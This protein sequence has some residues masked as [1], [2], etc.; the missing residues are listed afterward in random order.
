MRR[1]VQQQLIDLL[2]TVK[3]GIEYLFASQGEISATLAGDCLA[4]L[5]QLSIAIEGSGSRKASLYI[6]KLQAISNDLGHGLTANRL[7]IEIQRIESVQ[8]D[9]RQEPVRFEIAFL[10]YKSSMWDCMESVWRAAAA[11]KNCDCHVVPIPYYERIPGQSLGTFRYEGRMLPP[12]VPIVDYKSYDLARRKPDVIYIHNPNDEYNFLTSIDPNYYSYELKRHTDMLVYL[13]YYVAGYADDLSSGTLSALP[14]YQYADR[15]VVQS[16]PMRQGLL[17]LGLPSERI[18]V[19]GSPKFDAVINRNGKGYPAEWQPKLK[20]RTAFLV[21]TSLPD[22]LYYDGTWLDRME[23]MMQSILAHDDCAVIWRPHPLIELTIKNM[24]K[25]LIGRYQEMKQLLL[26]HNNLVLDMNSA[27]LSAFDASDALIGDY[28]SLNWLYGAT[29]KPVL[30]MSEC[31][32][33]VAT[34]KY[35]LLDFSEFYF[36]NDG[37]SIESFVD[38]VRKGTDPNRNARISALSASIVNMDGTAGQAIHRSIMNE[39]M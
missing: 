15:V 37:M 35:C 9:L 38:M 3:A 31:K 33:D 34:A 25:E 21:N 11:D 24:R 39:F 18:L 8:N 23:N 5:Q 17:D 6:E 13:P 26:K 19:L 32:K 27:Y 28:S 4:A 1:F 10:P 36:V 20:G 29:G 7:Q 30:C 12:E 22:L 14:V 16:E 2:D